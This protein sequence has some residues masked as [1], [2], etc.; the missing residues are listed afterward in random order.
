MPRLNQGRS[1]QVESN[2]ARRIAYERER[3]GLSYEALAEAMTKVGC[4]INASSIYKIEKGN[5]PRRISVDELAA[6]AEVF[7]EPLADLLV[8]MAIIEQRRAQDLIDALS[9]SRTEVNTAAAQAFEALTLLF[10][11]AAADS[12]L[13]EY[14]ENHLESRHMRFEFSSPESVPIS[15][16]TKAVADA[17]ASQVS[18]ASSAHWAAL[19]DA[20]QIWSAFCRGAWTP[21]LQDTVIELGQAADDA[22]QRA[23][24][25]EWLT[26]E[27]RRER[28]G[29]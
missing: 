8:D 5:P 20:A 15:D 13:A 23:S 17:L 14:V 10:D 2:L 24:E 12:D 26:R 9:R 11:L 4:A 29:G 19:M 27:I 18:Y 28:S 21:K 1:L 25:L 3:R 16:A 6:L 7:D 22:E